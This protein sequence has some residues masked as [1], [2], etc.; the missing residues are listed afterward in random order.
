MLS[1]YNS[2][3]SGFCKGHSI[4]TL[5][6]KFRDDIQKALN[7]NEITISV[8]IDYSKAFG[9][10]DHEFLIRKLVSLNFSTSSIK[11]ILNYLTNQKEYVQV[12]DNNLNG[13]QYTS[14]SYKAVSWARFY[15]TSMLLNYQ[16]A[17]N[18]IQLVCR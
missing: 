7:R 8:V 15:S 4:Q 10:I 5:L 13:Y 3:Q 17:L 16:H 11:I 1:V 6:L 12:N 9:T 14:E 2:T 18:Q